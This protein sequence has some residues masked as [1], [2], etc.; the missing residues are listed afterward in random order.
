MC[1]ACVGKKFPCGRINGFQRNTH[2]SNGVVREISTQQKEAFVSNCDAF[3]VHMLDSSYGMSFDKLV[4]EIHKYQ[5]DYNE[6]LDT[7]ESIALSLVRMLEF[8]FVKLRQQRE[9]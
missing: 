6:Q 2:T 5:T 3:I 1:G 7:E 9:Q 8:G 4:A